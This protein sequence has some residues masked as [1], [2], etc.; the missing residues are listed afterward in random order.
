[1]EHLPLWLRSRTLLSKIISSP[2]NTVTYLND[3]LLSPLL[4]HGCSQKTILFH[5]QFTECC[6]SSPLDPGGHSSQQPFCPFPC[7]SRVSQ[8]TPFPGPFLNLTMPFNQAP[9]PSFSGCQRLDLHL[10]LQEPK[11][12]GPHEE[13]FVA[14]HF[15]PSLSMAFL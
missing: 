13:L 12:P 6:A 4:W 3:F 10:C 11:W 1:M 8:S 15:A 7:L 9:W 5:W 14:S 2:H